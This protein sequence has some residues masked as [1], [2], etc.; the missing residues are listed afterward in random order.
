MA[1]QDGSTAIASP[2]ANASQEDI[3]KWLKTI[4]PKL[5]ADWIA[6]L[7]KSNLPATAHLQMHVLKALDE[8]NMQPMQKFALLDVLRASAY[9]TVDGLTSGFMGSASGF[10]EEF[11]SIINQ[12][13]LLQG[14]LAS[15]YTN[16]AITARLQGEQSLFIMG[17]AL[18]RAMMDQYLMLCFYLQLFLPV[19]QH[20]WR[21]MH[22][23]FKV[24]EESQLLAHVMGDNVFASEQMLTIKQ[25]YLAA[26]LMG[27][28]RCNQLHA[29]DVTITAKALKKW[30]LHADV[31]KQQDA[32]KPHQLAVDVDSGHSPCFSLTENLDKGK[33][34]RYLHTG[35]LVSYLQKQFG[36]A[37]KLGERNVTLP[38]NL[39]RHLIAAWS[40]YV[41]RDNTRHERDD[42][43]TSSIG[44]DSLHYYLT[45]A[46]EVERFIGET[47]QTPEPVANRKLV[48]GDDVPEEFNFR[49]YLPA[50]IN[51]IEQAKYPCFDVRVINESVGG[52]CLEWPLE[53][54]SALL[55]GEV[56]G[57]KESFAPYWKVGEIVWMRKTEENKVRIGVRTLSSE[58]IPL[59]AK[60][61][62]NI[63]Q[64]GNHLPG[65]LLPKDP[66]L[67]EAR[68][69]FLVPNVKL[70]T[71]EQL[72]VI[73]EG[74]EQAIQ[75]LDP[76][77]ETSAYSQFDCAYL[78]VQKT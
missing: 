6:K 55:V 62:H 10:S 11:K 38:D 31:S 28:A 39:L 29:E 19:P 58:A 52:Y 4:T 7:P 41:E 30:A 8:V 24:S 33:N 59:V 32:G 12:A 69:T 47:R 3:Q 48:V 35:K 49:A 72:K 76:V 75:L 66:E 64:R 60:V 63:E 61:L 13:M 25:I 9:Q 40:E 74:N 36:S 44:M 42:S 15:S 65:M 56:I 46:I 57:I 70:K 43:V 67:G 27:C 22:R 26:V 50:D 21:H 14:Q 18:H 51:N 45:G 68:T 17:S 1:V 16:V 20:L 53:I 73:Q 2:D 23:L 77:K 37:V 54:Q 5:L 71:G 34:W 78:V